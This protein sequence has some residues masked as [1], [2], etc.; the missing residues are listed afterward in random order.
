MCWACCAARCWLGT[1]HKPLG[2]VMPQARSASRPWSPPSG[3]RWHPCRWPLHCWPWR[4][5]FACTVCGT[6]TKGRATTRYRP[7]ELG[8]GRLVAAGWLDRA[9]F[10]GPARGLWLFGHQL[11][12]WFDHRS[13]PTR[14]V[15]VR[16]G[17]HL[18]LA[19]HW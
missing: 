6:L 3:G 14:P 4:C 19:D 12:G 16:G 10:F 17:P 5:C 8:A 2:P 7:H 15:F 18:H 13:G 11:G 1:A 9:D